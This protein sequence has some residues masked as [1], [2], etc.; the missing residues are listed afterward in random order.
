MAYPL[1]MHGDYPVEP[2]RYETM[3]SWIVPWE[4][5]SFEAE[6]HTLRTSVALINASTQALIQVQGE[7]RVVFLH[8][9]LSQ[10]I[11]KLQPGSIAAAALLSA[12]G[13]LIAPMLV[14]CEEASLWL[15]VEAVLSDLVVKTL[16]TYL[17]QESVVI[18]NCERSHAVFALE[19]PRTSALINSLLPEA[20]LVGPALS[21]VRVALEGIPL[22]LL[23]HS[24]IGSTQGIVLL[25]PVE[26]AKQCWQLL[27][28][29][30]KSEGLTLV[31]WNA[32]NTARLESAIPWFGIDI[33][34]DNLLP[35]TGLQSILAS[36]DKGCYLGQEIVARLAAYGSLNKRLMALRIDGRRVP[37]AGA[38]IIVSGET[39]G[40]LTSACPSPRLGQIIGL[41]YLKR[42]FYEVGQAV[43]I[44]DGKETIPAVVAAIPLVNPANSAQTPAGA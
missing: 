7:D 31:G 21:H 42:G 8:N 38:A 19:G 26:K 13:K 1:L 14:L 16:N 18:K 29:R 41:G 22:W 5:T 12:N 9:L 17:F 39:V 34:A 27:S 36:D 23:R 6:Y 10:H 15:M 40:K 32:L 37:A 2:S 4:F 28:A 35:E 24:F 25:V 44:Q 11:K 33:D 30:G 3:G 20:A 43:V